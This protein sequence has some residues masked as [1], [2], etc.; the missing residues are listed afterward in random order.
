MLIK[1]FLDRIS[2][3]QR[4]LTSAWCFWEIILKF[5]RRNK[6]RIYAL[7]GVLILVPENI[8]F[9]V[10]LTLKFEWLRASCKL[11]PRAAVSLNNDQKQ[12]FTACRIIY[13]TLNAYLPMAIYAAR[14]REKW[15]ASHLFLVCFQREVS[16][17]VFSYWSICWPA[18]AN[19]IYNFQQKVG[20]CALL[21]MG[22]YSEKRSKENEREI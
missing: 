6:T 11:R 18:N 19:N 8:K 14:E 13:T 12:H 22:F 1:Y 9:C 5:N 20:S 7:L 10:S 15:V 4:S 16:G 21:K 17:D 2:E 3:W